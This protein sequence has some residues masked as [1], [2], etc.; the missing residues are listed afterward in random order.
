MTKEQEKQLKKLM[1]KYPSPVRICI[2]D[3]YVNQGIKDLKRF[4]EEVIKCIEDKE[5]SGD[6]Y[7][8]IK[9]EI[10]MFKGEMVEVQDKEEGIK[11]IKYKKPPTR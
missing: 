8:T 7:T 11:K 4:I 1:K 3:L 9:K 6:D 10:G 2:N 5:G